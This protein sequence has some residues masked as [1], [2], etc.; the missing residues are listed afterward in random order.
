MPDVEHITPYGVNG[1]ERSKGEQVRDMFDDIAP[2]YDAMNR[3]MTLGVDLAWRRRCVR[4]AV[5]CRPEKVLDIA[6]GTGDLAIAIAKALPKARVTGVD[7]SEGMIDKGRAKL[8]AKRLDNR[9]D[10]QVADA[11]RLPFADNAFD[12]V[13]IAFGVRNFEHL[14]RGYAEM[15]RVLRPGGKLIVLELTTPR[16]APVRAL[17]NLYAGKIIPFVGRLV[18]RNRRAYEYLPESIAAVP[19]RR[20]MTAI[21]EDVGFAEARHKSLTM[22]VA[23]I[24]EAVKPVGADSGQN[25]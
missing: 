9:V 21:M 5:A 4:M 24:Y 22:S 14:H 12:V 10:M 15:L 13:T 19:A 20:T 7:L 11:M 3:M 1:D 6:T 25:L 23:A 8:T 2:T 17:Y 16:S 18:S